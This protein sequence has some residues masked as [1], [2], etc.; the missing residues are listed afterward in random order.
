M[1]AY[2]LDA[3]GNTL[4]YVAITGLAGQTFTA[5]LQGIYTSADGTLQSEKVDQAGLTVSGNIVTGKISEYAR[6]AVKYSSL[7]N[8]TYTAVPGSVSDYYSTMPSIT[9]GYVNEKTGTLKDEA[10]RAALETSTTAR[11]QGTVK[12]VVAGDADSTLYVDINDL[13]INQ[14]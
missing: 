2:Y 4:G 13:H 12:I 11:Y 5:P 14:F 1:K 10:T 6:G 9:D 7:S 8:T 3:D